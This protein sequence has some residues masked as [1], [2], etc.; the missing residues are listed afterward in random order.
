MNIRFRFNEFCFTGTL[1]NFT[2]D[3]ATSLIEE[4]GG[5]VKKSLTTNTNYII[6]GEKPGQAK[7]AKLA[8]YSYKYVKQVT[9]TEFAASL[10]T[11]MKGFRPRKN[12]EVVSRNRAVIAA[13][14][15][16]LKKTTKVV[17]KRSRK[18]DI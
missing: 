4:R 15:A 10:L 14:S 18:F 1:K 17:Q 6:V 7:M 9:E 8:R 13:S 11:S 12:T 5:T 3:Q 16:P 2:R